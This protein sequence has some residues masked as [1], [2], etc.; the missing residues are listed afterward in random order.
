[1]LFVSQRPSTYSQGKMGKF[2]GDRGGVGKVA[3]WSTK[4]S[5]SPKRE[6]IEEKLLWGAYRNSTTLF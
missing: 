6:K 4:A 2:G 1:M 3:C 5:I